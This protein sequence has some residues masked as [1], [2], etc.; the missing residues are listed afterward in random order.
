METDTRGVIMRGETRTD[1]VLLL[2]E[3]LL[4]DE[5]DDKSLQKID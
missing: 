3:T 2:V 5:G 1:N 4:D